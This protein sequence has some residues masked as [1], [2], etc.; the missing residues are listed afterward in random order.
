MT[1]REYSLVHSVRLK[2]I[3]YHVDLWDKRAPEEGGGAWDVQDVPVE[4]T[5]QPKGNGKWSVVDIHVDI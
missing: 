1:K 4:I 5:L 2:V 3:A